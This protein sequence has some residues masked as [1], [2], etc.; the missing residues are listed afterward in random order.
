MNEL[1]QYIDDLVRKNEALTIKLEFSNAEIVRLK[2]RVEELESGEESS[3][4]NF[5][6]VNNDT[7][8]L[9][10]SMH[11]RSRATRR[12]FQ[13]PFGRRSVDLNVN[14]RV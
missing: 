3:A 9:S 4:V 7:D 2:M 13:R 8:Q 14:D 11:K 1:Y 12:S 10:Q 6:S 5:Q